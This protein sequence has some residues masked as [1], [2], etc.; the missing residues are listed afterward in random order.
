MQLR[1]SRASNLCSN[2]VPCYGC[3]VRAFQAR[4]TRGWQ[5]CLASRSD[6]E[7]TKSPVLNLRGKEDAVQMRAEAEAPF[8]SLR[9]VF[10]GFSVV[11]ASLGFL[12]SIPQLIGA[13]AS[14]R[15]ALPLEQV[16]QNL[17]IDAAAIALFAFLFKLD[18]E[19]REKQLA[20]LQ[21]EETL[22]ALPIRLAS[23]KTL[24]LADLRGS[25]RVVLAA[26]TRQQ[27][28]AAL[29]EAEPFRDELVKRGVVVVP[30]AIF[31]EGTDV[32][33]SS[34]SLPPTLSR[35]GELPQ[36]TPSDLRWRAEP[37]R[38]ADWQAWFKQQLSYSAKAKPENGLFV[39][40][41]LD[42]RVRSSGSGVPPWRR[43]AL[44]LA[45]LEGD[46]KW[47]GFFDGF[48]GRV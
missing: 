44:E 8:R 39:G 20:R 5:P 16:Q 21:R 42:G 7:R 26:G 46:G 34:S 4:R 40:L 14:T 37:Q 23:G 43:Y 29:R 28:V 22:G 6:G 27:V 3:R 17:A 35:D 15:N 18:W 13:L 48:D 41:R 24:T 1:S 38:L 2:A 32:T 45:P 31:G 30:V 9:L 33:T 47:T 25:A 11:S 12:I 36:L 19:A 10:S